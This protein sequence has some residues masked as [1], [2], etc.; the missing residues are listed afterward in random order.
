V[1][2]N[3][4]PDG[5]LIAL[6]AYVNAKLRPLSSVTFFRVQYEDGKITQ[7]MISEC[8][9]RRAVSHFKSDR[10]E[11]DADEVIKAVEDW[12]GAPRVQDRYSLDPADAESPDWRQ[13]S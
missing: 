7:A 6:A 1:P 11:H 5:P 13:M 4:P 3:L 2:K 10:D 8:G 12:I 9:S